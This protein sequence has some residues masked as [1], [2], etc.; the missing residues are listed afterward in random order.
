MLMQTPV[1]SPSRTVAPPSNTPT[2]VFCRS[3]TVHWRSLHLELG[4]TSLH[5]CQQSGHSC[6]ST[7][8]ATRICP[9]SPQSLCHGVSPL[10]SLSSSYAPMQQRQTP[11]LLAFHSL[12]A[13]RV[14]HRVP[15]L[16]THRVSACIEKTSVALTLRHY[17]K[18]SDRAMSSTD[19]RSS[20][21]TSSLRACSRSS[22]RT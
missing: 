15:V 2:P 1:Q 3:H 4:T 13:D 7:W 19:F 12:N 20:F 22:R 8:F 18:C 6:T 5:E 14:E 17:S 10:L 21:H 9:R 11:R 16:E